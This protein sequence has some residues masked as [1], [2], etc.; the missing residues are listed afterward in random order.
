M[1]DEKFNENNFEFSYHKK[2]KMKDLKRQKFVNQFE[3]I[4]LHLNVF[5]ICKKW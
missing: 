1:Y 3:S 2:N 4:Y 5:E